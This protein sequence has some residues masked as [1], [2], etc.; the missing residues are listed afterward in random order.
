MSCGND[1]IKGEGTV[2]VPEPGSLALLGAGLLG[3]VLVRR[4]RLAPART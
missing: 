4:R 3:L 2:S 1:V